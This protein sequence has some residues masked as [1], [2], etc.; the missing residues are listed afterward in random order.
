MLRYICIAAL[1]IPAVATAQAPAR[2]A[3][4]PL[5][6]EVATVR[7][8]D[9][10]HIP[11]VDL[12]VY[13]GGHLVIRAH[14]LAML[15]AEAFN[16]PESQITGGNQSVVQAWYDVEG[17]APEELRSAMP[18]SEHTPYGNIQDPRVRSMLQSLLIERFHLR[19]HYQSKPGTVYELKRS[20]GSLRLQPEEQ[21]SDEA[22][23]GGKVAGYSPDATGLIILGQDKPVGIYQT[24]MLQLAHWLTRVEQAPV[25]DRT[26]L[27]GFYNFKSHTMVTIEDFKGDGPNHL[28]VESLPEMG[29]KLV[30]THGKVQKFVI[31]HAE[32][33]SAN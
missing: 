24:S 6:F 8:D 23:K 27:P 28:I 26:G 3:G 33:P 13:P 11:P 16:I 31:D 29:L 7:Q 12:R 18:G 2:A 1:I 32:L 25:N 30:K 14:R 15:I 17:K 22:S 21:N 9:Q 20:K 5:A 10:K 19:F 4:T